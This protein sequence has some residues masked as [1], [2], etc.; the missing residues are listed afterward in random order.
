MDARILG[1]MS[2]RSSGSAF[3]GIEVD[4]PTT[5]EKLLA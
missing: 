3:E 2:R 4:V 1:G 5:P